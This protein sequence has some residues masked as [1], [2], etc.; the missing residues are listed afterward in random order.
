MQVKYCRQEIFLILSKLYA[1]HIM[2]LLLLCLLVLV[3]LVQNSNIVDINKVCITGYR[4][5]FDISG[6][7]MKMHHQNNDSI[8]CKNHSIWYQ[9]NINDENLIYVIYYTQFEN[10]ITLLN[11]G[12]AFYHCNSD[13]YSNAMRD[14]STANNIDICVDPRFVNGCH[15]SPLIY[16]LSYNECPQYQQ[17]LSANIASIVNQ[18]HFYDCHCWYQM[19]SGY[20]VNDERIFLDFEFNENLETETEN[21]CEKRNNDDSGLLFNEYTNGNRIRNDNNLHSKEK[22][23]G[24]LWIWL[25]IFMGICGTFIALILLYLCYTKCLRTGMRKNMKKYTSTSTMIDDENNRFVCDGICDETDCTTD[26]VF[27]GNEST[28][29]SDDEELGI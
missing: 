25:S 22:T 2:T 14:Y 1:K 9:T 20:F 11:E 10:N 29:I 26:D 19:N 12:Y 3:S 17:L 16:C 27:Y 15:S 23:F 8:T 7:Y 5:L 18:K 28:C 6:L 21:F 24:V 4:S 13:Q